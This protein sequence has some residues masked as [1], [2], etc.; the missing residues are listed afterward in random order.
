MVGPHLS[1]PILIGLPQGGSRV[2]WSCWLAVLTLLGLGP[3]G[4]LAAQTTPPNP[5]AASQ[6]ESPKPIAGPAVEASPLDTIYLRDN[7]GNLVPVSGMSFEEFQQLLHQKKG[8]LPP[9][10]PAYS[11]DALTLTGT[12]DNGTA[13]IQITAT[14]RV[15]QEGWVRIPLLMPTAHVRGESKHEGPGEHFL[16]YDAA[17]GGYICWLKGAADQPH[18]VTISAAAGVTLVGEYQRLA[19]TLPRA[20]ESSLRL[21]VPL[22]SCEALLTG[23]GLATTRS[24]DGGRSEVSVLGPAGELQLSWRMGRTTTA[25]GPPQFDASGEIQVRVDSQRS[26][27]STAQIKVQSYSGLLETF[28]VRLPAGMELENINRAGYTVTPLS[29]AAIGERRPKADQGQVVEVRLDKPAAGLTTVQISAAL[30]A[31]ANPPASLT[32]A[33]FDVLGAVRQRGTIDVVVPGQWQLEWTEDRSV[34]RLD[35]AAEATPS[36]AVARFEYFR[37]P[38]GL[39]LRVSS[40]PSRISVEPT[41]VVSV[42]AQQLRIKSTFKYKFR[43]SRA[44]GLTLELGDWKFVGLTPGDHLETPVVKGDAAGTVQVAFRAEVPAELELTLEAHQPLTRPAANIQF[45]LPRPLADVVAP[46]TLVIAPDD[47]IELSPQ[48]ALLAGLSPDPSGVRIRGLQQ[49]PL[50]YRDLGGGEPALFAAGMRIRARSTM[51]A[52]KATVRLDRRRIQV[53]QRLDYRIAYEPQRTFTLLTPRG[54]LTSSNLQVLWEGTPLAVT[55]LPGPPTSGDTT[56]QQLQFSTPTDQIGGCQV[57]VQYALPS[58]AWD[59]D[60]PTALTVP[61]AI[62]ADDGEQLGLQQL[63]FMLDEGWQVEAESGGEFSRPTPLPSGAGLVSFSLPRATPATRWIVQPSFAGQPTAIVVSKAWIQTWLSPR[64]RQERATYRLTTAQDSLRIQLPGRS[65]VGNLQAALNGQETP[66][67]KVREDGSVRID[68]PP[69]MRGRECTLELWYALQ[70][71]ERSL[72]VATS[73]LQPALVDGAASPRRTFWQVAL[74][75]NEHLLT[76]PSELA[77]EMVWSAKSWL[78]LREPLHGQR[79]LEDWIRGSHQDPLP[80]GVQIY[81]FGG[82]GCKPTFEVLAIHRR[83]L[84]ALASGAVLAVGLAL[85]QWSWLRRPAAVLVLATVLAAMALAAPD[86]ALLVGQAAVLGLLVLAGA[87]AWNWSSFGPSARPMPAA[88]SVVSRAND[89]RPRESISTQPPAP[90]LE[91]ATPFNGSPP[92]ETAAVEARS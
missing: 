49:Q 37:Q 20:T 18:V 19:L 35:L 92:G 40:R 68:L 82:M 10:A 1:S 65:L 63:D 52:A 89:S 66:A 77:T 16:S 53:E 3:H 13:A 28:Q 24:V 50:V 87:V 2:R 78:P 25:K 60:K 83:L 46:A 51:V 34:R 17:A 58:P 21:T 67:L 7:K 64:V 85:L 84:L 4:R 44:A 14:I 15:R 6:A 43:G 32:P 38:C 26:I 22:A 81:L 91:A 61:L 42:D 71:P 23:D 62:P 76:G 69:A 41:H 56:T 36:S 79:E 39:Q 74:P 70:S 75:A 57:V 9:A 12:T 30:L 72:G 90:R 80:R 88:S 11:L 54:L 55:A 45:T 29:A 48:A 31:D 5:P 59:G 73:R 27:T 33:R 86:A 47:N 8:L